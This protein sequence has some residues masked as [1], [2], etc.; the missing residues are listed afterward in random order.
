FNL[1][2]LQK[3]IYLVKITTTNGKYETVKIVKK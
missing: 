2:T 3:G 1:E